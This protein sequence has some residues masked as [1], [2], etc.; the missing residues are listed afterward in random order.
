MSTQK[1]FV[2]LAGLLTVFTVAYAAECFWCSGK[3][4]KSCRDCRGSGYEICVRCEGFGRVGQFR[5]EKCPSCKGCKYTLDTCYSC[6][7]TG[8]QKKLFGKA[9]CNK[10][11]GLGGS[12]KACSK[13]NG[14]GVVSCDF[15]RGTGQD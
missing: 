15:C 5:S 12:K 7:G 2:I 8:E 10:C 6:N 3:G 9:K 11:N 1:L 14:Y 4:K 13:C